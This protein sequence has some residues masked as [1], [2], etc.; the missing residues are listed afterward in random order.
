MR[1]FHE[2]V[3]RVPRRRRTIRVRERFQ[4]KL[5][6][7]VRLVVLRRMKS[8]RARFILIRRNADPALIELNDH[9]ERVHKTLVERATEV[10]RTL[11]KIRLSDNVLTV[12]HAQVKERFRTIALARLG[13]ELDRFRLFCVP[14]IAAIVKLADYVVRLAE[15]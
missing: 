3:Q 10:R 2:I 13:V 15:T 7:G 8:R 14:I 5:A 12:S 1:R 4:A 9:I 6:N 11:H